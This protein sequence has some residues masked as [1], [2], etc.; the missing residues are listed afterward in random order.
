MNIAFLFTK[1]NFFHFYGPII[2]ECMRRGYKISLWFNNKEKDKENYLTIPFIKNNLKKLSIEIFDFEI[3]LKSKINNNKFDYFLSF[4]PVTFE[5]D[6]TIRKKIDGKWCM[7]CHIPDTYALIWYWDVYKSFSKLNQNYK[8]YF[9]GFTEHLHN[10]FIDLIKKNREIG[11]RENEIFFES[12]LTTKKFYGFNLLDNK[13]LNQETKVRE[14]YNFKNKKILIY[15]PFPFSIKKNAY[16][17]VDYSW[18]AAYSG[19]FNGFNNY[20]SKNIYR[21]P[22]DFLKF[23]IFQ[24]RLLIKILMNAEARYFY[25]NGLNEISLVKSIKEFCKKNDYLLVV[26][27]RKKFPV[28]EYIQEIADNY[29][30]EDTNQFYPDQLQELLSVSNLVVG[31][32][33][34][35]V[36]EVVGSKSFYVNIECPHSFFGNYF[37]RISRHS[38][39]SGSRYNSPGVTKSYKI[40]DIIENFNKFT[41]DIFATDK[42]EYSKYKEKYLGNNFLSSNSLMCDFLEENLYNK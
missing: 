12:K 42:A 11:L 16:L 37:P 24:T 32:Y 22:L 34:S 14:K 20:R 25:M 33:T 27:S 19:I 2:S 5:I 9:F 6:E 23:L 39:E 4:E 15:L 13:I 29:I 40:I 36:F 28:P 21:L 38:T 1:L 26:K 41:D 17:D 35:A 18:E 30:E 3:E 8:R 10:H 7:I 31:Y